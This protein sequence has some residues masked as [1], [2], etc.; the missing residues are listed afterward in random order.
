MQR[1]VSFFRPKPSSESESVS[2]VQASVEENRNVKVDKKKKNKR[3]GVNSNHTVN[4]K[5]RIVGVNSI[6]ISFKL[7]SLDHIISELSPG[8]ICLQETKMRKVG[9]IKGRNTQKYTT[10]ELVRQHSGGGGL[11]TMVSSDLFP[12]WISEGD[13]EV[14]ILVVQVHIENMKV[15]ILNA[16]GP[17]V[18]DH[19]DRKRAFWNRLH[20]EFSEAANL[21]VDCLLQMDGN[22]HAGSE[23]IPGDPNDINSNGK[24]FEEFLKNNPSVDLI[25]GT[26]K[27]SG[28]VTRYRKKGAKIEQA[29]LDF[30]CVS[31]NLETYIKSLSIDHRR[32]YP[33]SSYLKDKPKHSDHFTLIIDLDIQYQR[34][35]KVRVEQ[36]NFHSQEGLD[37]LKMIL[38]SE[39]NLLNC[40]NTDKNPERQ[41]EDWFL[42]FD[43]ILGRCFKKVRI[44]DTRKETEESKLFKERT[45]LVQKLKR[46]P[47]NV[48][49][50][51]EKDEVELKLSKLVSKD[52]MEKISK[53]F[54]KL[55]Q[56]EGESFSQGIWDLK[57]KLF[58]K[59]TPTPPA[60]KIDVTGRMVTD[61]IGLKKLYKETFAHRLRSRPPKESVTDIIELQKKLLEKRLAVTE[62]EV[63]PDWTELDVKTVLKNLKNGKSRDPL[64]LINEIFKVE[65]S[66]LVKSLT[67]MMNTVKKTQT[68]PEPFTIKNVTT[69]YKKKGSRRDLKNDRGIF[70]CTI[71]HSIY[72]KL[73]YKDIYPIIDENLTDSNVGARKG[74]NIRNHSWIVNSVIHETIS[75]K[76]KSKPVEI[77]ILDYSCCFDSMSLEI[78]TNDLYNVGIRT[79]LLNLLYNS[80]KLN[81]VAIKT[82]FGLTDRF[83]VYDTVAQGDVIAPM[84]CTVQVD[85]ISEAHAINLEGNLYKYKN[86]VELPPLG[87]IDDQ[88]IITNCGLDSALASSHVNC[89]TNLK[90]LQF[91]ADKC[92]K[93]HV[94][95]DK[96]ICPDNQ[97]DT[98]SSEGDKNTVSSIL[99]LKDVESEKHV[100]ET[101]PSWTYLGDVLQNN[102]KNDLNI[103]SRVERGAAAKKQ[104]IQMLEE[105]T[106][107]DYHFEGAMILRNSLFLSSLLSNCEAWVNLTMKNVTDLETVDEQLLRAIL[108]AHPKTPIELLYLELGVIPVRFILMSRRMNFL[109]YLIHDKEESLLKNF[110]Q[111]QCDQPTRGDWVSTVKQDLTEVNIDMSF[112]E[113]RNVSKEA[114]KD[115]VK[116]R[117]QKLALVYLKKLQQTH[118]KAK[119]LSYE[120]LSLQSYLKSGTT[121]MTI[122]EK[123]FAFATRSRT[124][125]VRCNK[126]HGE[127]DLKCRLGCSED[128]NQTHLLNC[129]ALINTDI[130]KDIPIYED[131]LSN[132]A[133]KIGNIS[134]ILQQKLKLLKETNDNCHVHSSQKACAA[135]TNNIDNYIPNVNV[136]IDLVEDLD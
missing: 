91:G 1:T 97:I 117:I 107:G 37:K 44:T 64:G 127:T 116:D 46:D 29:I 62:D 33:L 45:E 80:D 84:K 136:D 23:M 36:F 17:Q 96:K 133:I 13:D 92:V 118:V 89:M 132:D 130:V 56:T 63:S 59:I 83:P 43:K 101:K 6:G 109:W 69:V 19:V 7:R 99:D 11:A 86:K 25:N 122:K 111:A 61:P 26:S 85:S 108:S 90:K 12:V 124:L 9:R 5:L 42:A 129:K 18:N 31:E 53:N 55:D 41:I 67:I 94:G 113:I 98:W 115:L 103:Q 4:N 74:R 70:T 38:N 21:G 88:L 48:Q 28:D 58:P 106:L 39:N 54:S 105:L 125:D 2:P 24:L 15:R 16:Y 60:A 87:Q 49:L 112:E 72:Q 82:P 68:S 135:S 78:T 121:N 102:G 22:L 119:P 50:V 66:D 35:K 51:E 77:L 93:L 3:R 79:Q 57:K 27:C 47:G 126:M 104:V 134:R 95:T 75:T 14:E 52:N 100:M 10:F 123:S 40:F 73:I 8:V 20:E 32:E 131:V 110:F 120:K 76:S 34:R 30:V 114:F 128:E 81:N 65:G 71:P